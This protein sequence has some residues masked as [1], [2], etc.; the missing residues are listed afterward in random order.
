VFSSFSRGLML[1]MIS[2]LLQDAMAMEEMTKKLEPGCDVD[3]AVLVVQKPW[4]LIQ[5]NLHKISIQ[6]AFGI[7]ITTCQEPHPSVY[8]SKFPNPI[9]LV[10]KPV[11]LENR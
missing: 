3:Q 1:E 10:G 9:F 8:H 4:T 7:I 6:F 5:Q 11:Q 2:D